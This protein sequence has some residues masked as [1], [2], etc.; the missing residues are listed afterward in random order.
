MTDPPEPGHG[1]PVEPLREA[2]AQRGLRLELE[3]GR[4]GMAAVYRAYDLKHDRWVAV[5]VLDARAGLGAERLLREIQLAS[6]LVHPHIVPIYDSGQVVGAP[7]LMM[8]LVEGETLRVRLQ[9]DGRLPVEE[10]LRI[11]RD[12]ADALTYA[13]ARGV[14]HRDIKPE[15]ILLHEGHALVT[16]FGVALETPEAERGGKRLTDAGVAVGTAEYMSP[17]QASGEVALDGRSDLYSL[18]CVL[19]EMLAGKSPFAGGSVRQVVAR[20]FQG[21][22]PSVRRERPDV[23]PAL[24]RVIA[25]ALAVDPA[26]RFSTASG[27]ARALTGEALPPRHSHGRVR[28]YLW[29]AWPV[30]LAAGG[31]LLW[32]LG[33][34]PSLDP[35]RVVV[36]TFSNETADASLNYL[37]VVSAERIR[38]AVARTPDAIVATS[39]TILPSQV[40]PGLVHDT[41]D[42]PQRVRALAAETGSGLV[43]SGSYYRDAGEISFLCEITDASQGRMVRAIGPIKAA[44]SAPESAV[45]SLSAAVGSAI[46]TVLRPPTRSPRR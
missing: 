45:D 4:G 2:L 25:T 10:A 8:P 5:K 40:D 29:R 1:S 19:Y 46:E 23:S 35:H 33:R 3:I 37:S 7:Y 20:R 36:G 22:A 9:R 39:A 32:L 21:P 34:R 41:L 12:V 11:A 43:V 14:I 18:G 44:L 30:G 26:E 6:P 16:D 27:F 15:N 17:E 24:Q 28:R 13:H 38:L 42:D 31:L